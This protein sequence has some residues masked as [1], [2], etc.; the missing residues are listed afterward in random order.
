MG[1]AIAAIVGGYCIAVLAGWTCLR[2]DWKRHG[3]T[4][5]MHLDMN[6]NKTVGHRRWWRVCARCGARRPAELEDT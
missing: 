5:H 4:R 1:I 6:T 2:H 3:P